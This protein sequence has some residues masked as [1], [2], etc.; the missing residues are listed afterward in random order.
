[1]RGCEE[2][3]DALGITGPGFTFS[4][5]IPFL[6]RKTQRGKAFT[7]PVFSV[8]LFNLQTGSSEASII[9]LKFDR[10]GSPLRCEV[11]VAKNAGR[12]VGT[13]AKRVS[14]CCCSV[15]PPSAF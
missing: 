1:M 3:K 11:Y 12:Q 9:H 7:Q 8:S 2:G 14:W 6:E 4:C 13:V 5:S 10:E 15:T